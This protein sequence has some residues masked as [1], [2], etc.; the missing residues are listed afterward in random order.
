[1]A[2]VAQYFRS[3]LPRDEAVC[4][5]LFENV[6]DDLFKNIWFECIKKYDPTLISMRVIGITKQI[7][8]HFMIP[9]IPISYYEN[10]LLYYIDNVSLASERFELLCMDADFMKGLS[11]I[12]VE[13]T[14][15]EVCTYLIGNFKIISRNLSSITLP[16]YER[17]IKKLIDEQ[18]GE[19]HITYSTTLHDDKWVYHE[20]SKLYDLC[21][22]ANMTL[23]SKSITLL[24]TQVIKHPNSIGKQ[25]YL[26]SV[27]ASECFCL[28][29]KKLKEPCFKEVLTFILELVL[30]TEKLPS[31]DSSKRITSVLRPYFEF[32]S[33]IR[34]LSPYWSDVVIRVIKCLSLLKKVN[35][36]ALKKFASEYW[37]GFR[38]LSDFNPGPW[39]NDLM[40][41][42]IVEVRSRN[43]A[44]SASIQN[45][46]ESAIINSLYAPKMAFDVSAYQPI[47]T[48]VYNDEVR[49]GL[50]VEL[51]EELLE[52]W[53]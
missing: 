14:Y 21:I 10:L 18:S 50:A 36:D 5:N 46:F 33:I 8:A 35:K 38:V 7:A 9:K 22:C 17:V 27:T 39:I 32:F 44:S 2:N 28:P 6:P 19:A 41:R 51:A 45:N 37:T 4:L 40:E 15:Q 16:H 48:T 34:K 52:A 23:L 49:N 47:S 13:P 25:L 29:T 30:G 43:Q 12:A 26:L 31:A 24:S 42:D 11:K 53:K 20:I 1:M 3:P